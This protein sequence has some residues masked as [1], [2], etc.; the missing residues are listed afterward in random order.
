MESQ[1][2]AIHRKSRSAKGD[3]NAEDA[4]RKLRGANVLLVEDN[5]INKELAVELLESGGIT[6]SVAENGQVALAA[7]ATEVFDGVLM[8]CQMPVM[9]GYEPPAASVSRRSSVRC[10]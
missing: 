7:L 2:H 10:R 1:G 3:V 8:D 9:D 5:E 4:K 6:V